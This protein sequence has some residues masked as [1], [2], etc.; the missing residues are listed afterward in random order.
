MGKSWLRRLN[1]FAWAQRWFTIGAFVWLAATTAL[2]ILAFTREGIKLDV[3]FSIYLL[4]T[5]TCS[6]VAFVL[7]VIDKR[8]AMKNKPRI[9][10]RTMLT[11]N[12]LGG[13][14]GTHL[15]QRWFRHSTLRISYRFAFWVIV[16]IH[17]LIISW[18]C[19]TGWPITALRALLG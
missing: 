12:L 10:E 8:R 16:L 4:F 15:A 5:V 2:L 7:C 14:P 6:L 3:F 13:W 9:S 19:W 11:L 1:P 17:L 18:G